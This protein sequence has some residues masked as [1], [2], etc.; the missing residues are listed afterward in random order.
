MLEVANPI[1]LERPQDK[2]LRR[3]CSIL[4]S[5]MDQAQIDDIVRAYHFGAEAHT[6]QFRKSGEAYICHPVSVAIYLAE[7][8]MDAK[9]IMAA[10]LHDVLEDTSVTKKDLAHLFSTEVA[11][12]VDGVTKLSK[13]DSHSRAEAQAENVRKMFLAMTKDLR[14]IMVK[15]ADRLHNMQTLGV[16][17]PEKKRRIARETLDIYAPLANRLGMNQIKHQLE[18]LGFKALYPGRQLI[19]KNA[20]RKA[21]GNRREIV[22]T[23]ENSIK[24]RLQQAGLACEVVGREKNLYSIYQKMLTKKISFNDVFDVYAF[25]ILSDQVDTCYRALGVVH[26]LYKPVPGR[27]KDYIALSKANG[28]QSLHTILIGPYGVPIEIQIR[29]QEMHRMS[30]SGIAAHWLYKTDNEK[31]EHA[32]MR[33]NEWL[34]EL[35]EIHKSAGDSMEFIDNLKIDLYPQEVFVFTPQGGIIKLPRGATIVDFAYAV[36]TDIGNSCVSARIDKQL[37]PLQ[38][39]LE[40]GVTVE[41][42]T[43]SWARPNPLW[44]N[45]VVTAKARSS[46]RAYLKHFKQQEAISLGRRLL[47]KELQGMNLQLETISQERIFTLLDVLASPSLDALLEDIGLGNKMP[48]LVA[49]RLSQDDIY[50]A[51]KLE[52]NEKGVDTPLII[53]GTEGMVVTLAKCCRPIPG[54]SIVGFFNPGRGIVVHHHECRNS[55]DIRKK[56]TSWLDVEWSKETTG[57]FP[58]EIRLELLNQR[59]TLANVAATISEMD[60][61]IE[62]V[63]VV[64]QD[65]RVSVDL[66]TLTVRDRVHLANIMRR[67]RKLMIVLKITRVKA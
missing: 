33:A 64:D 54:D 14:V 51:I 65:D 6:G 66:I 21:R 37:V 67:L 18:S 35:L 27:F 23:I 60:S 3:L 39:Q 56:Q 61:N 32:Q 45:Y 40:N 48:F 29:T 59:G 4:E 13:I 62:N 36:H 42:I 9:G 38:T 63:T 50:A 44:L 57:E 53:K 16:M 25:R 55:N 41:V 47:E 15:L 10:L 26:N 28:Y 43:A 58:A 22:E 5:Y 20:V 19:L 1:E 31:T 46:I 49:K 7:M 34:R 24:N 2:L 11:E 17:P 52:D 12:L 8:R 30:E